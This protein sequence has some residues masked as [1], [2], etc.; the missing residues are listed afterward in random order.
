MAHIESRIIVDPEFALCICTYRRVELLRALLLDL[1]SQT[2]LPGTI[3]IVDGDPASGEV[4]NILKNISFPD[5]ISIGL[6]PSNHSN[7]PYQR[8]LGWL[9]SQEMDASFLLYLDDDLRL[10]QEDAIEKL[11]NYLKSDT[12][13]AGATSEIKFGAMDEFSSSQPA[14]VEHSKSGQNKSF[15]VHLLGS[16]RGIPPG[17]LT[18]SGHRVAPIKTGKMTISTVQW[19]RGG[20]MFFRLTA[21]RKEA[22]SEDLFALYHIHCGKGEDVFL[23]RQVMQFGKLIYAHDVI[24]EHPNSDLPKTYPISSHNLAYATALSRR[25]LNDHYIPAQSPRLVHRIQLLKSYMGN[26]LIYIGKALINPRRYRFAYAFGYGAGAFRGM[27]QSPTAKKL[28][29]HINWWEDAREALSQ[30]A[31]FQ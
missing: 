14:L 29:P 27:M 16:S 13:I 1:Q 21:L 18:P 19:L 8:Y 10:C 6:V 4:L 22:F 24:V 2:L 30:M 9:A 12:S 11:L 3:V 17:G 28:T 15:V 23:S 26:L 20:I 7:L 25:F 31:V 5:G